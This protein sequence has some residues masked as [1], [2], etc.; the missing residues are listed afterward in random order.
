[1]LAVYVPFPPIYQVVSC[2]HVTM[3][4]F[5]HATH[6]KRA[7]TEGAFQ[8]LVPPTFTDYCFPPAAAAAAY[9]LR[10]FIFLHDMFCVCV[11][12]FFFYCGFLQ[13]AAAFLMSFFPGSSEMTIITDENEKAEVIFMPQQYMHIL[14]L[15]MFCWVWRL[16]SLQCVIRRV[17]T[18]DF[19]W[20]ASF[21]FVHHCDNLQRA[22]QGSGAIK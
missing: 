2:T 10:L 4:Q 6:W 22:N 8:R 19:G 12:F 7:E 11:L 21:I 14:L 17:Y 18:R 15:S 9:S 16:L 5:S 13:S 20:K 3:P 1:M